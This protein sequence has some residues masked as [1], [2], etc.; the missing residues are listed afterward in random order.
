[1]STTGS[2]YATSCVGS[3]GEISATAE[4]LPEASFALVNDQESPLLISWRKDA[5]GYLH[6]ETDPGR[7]P[8]ASRGASAR[9]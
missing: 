5:I 7:T 1:M 2:V 8:A 9:W 4:E 3:S 6:I